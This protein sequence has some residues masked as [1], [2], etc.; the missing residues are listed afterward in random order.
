[1]LCIDVFLSWFMDISMIRVFC[2]RVQRAASDDLLQS[3]HFEECTSLFVTS[4]Q[5]LKPFPKRRLAGAGE[6][7]I[8]AAP[9]HVLLVQRIQ[10]DSPLIHGP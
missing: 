1:M 4:Q 5:H 7:E 6:V 8:G 3:G 2:R 9:L 10:E